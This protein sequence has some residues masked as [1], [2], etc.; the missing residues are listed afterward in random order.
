MIKRTLRQVIIFKKYMTKDSFIKEKKKY[1][2]NVLATV[3]S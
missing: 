2:Y 3:S 1:I